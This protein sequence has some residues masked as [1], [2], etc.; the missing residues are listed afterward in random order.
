MDN[1]RSEHSHGLITTS[2][3]PL[4]AV[5][6]MLFVSTNAPAVEIQELTSP[7]GIKVLLVEDY[8]VPIISIAFSFKG[9]ASQDPKGKE[10]T[11]RLMGALLDE[12]AGDLDNR[13]FQARLEETGVELGFNTTRDDFSASL[14]TL[15]SE[16]E[17]AF[18]L[19][20][21][22]LTKPRFD[23]E[24]IERMR[25]AIRR[26]IERG[27][28]NPNSIATR[29]RRKAVFK[30]HPYAR[31]SNGNEE[32][33][34][35]IARSD[36]I[37]I[38]QRILTRDNLSVGVVGAITAD[39][40]SVALDRV[41]GELPA[42]SAMKAV[43][44]VLPDLGEKISIDMQIPQAVVSLV[45]PGIKRSHPDF[46]A[47]HLMNHILG[48]GT[49][50]SRLYREV[51]EKRGLAYGVSSWIATYDHSAFLNASTSTRAE[52]L[53]ETLSIMRGQIEKVAK[54]GVSEAELEA[55][56][57]YVIGAYAINNLDTSTKIARV[58]V[59]L[60]TE[61]L[62]V[63]Y[64]DTRESQISAVTLDDVNRIARELLSV[65]PTI[66]IVGPVGN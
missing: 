63:D 60:Q 40:L 18:N 15:R 1:L 51:R 20:Q 6:M 59:A 50:S 62:G 14:R 10:G 36:I 28:T 23:D 53:D 47:S 52:N 64:I 66:V 39:E 65:E 30:N 31:D 27:R 16:R 46:F 35:D 3:A 4:I 49:F 56:R 38:H 5:I 9:G 34:G 8:S 54:E 22:A 12:G 37:A 55:A 41:F 11:L 44:D 17:N 32:S 13:A 45:Y 43:E 25:D 61:N 7:G 19:L 29:A 26:G 33:I 58:L 57:K 24:A 48:G 42:T 21:M 2:L